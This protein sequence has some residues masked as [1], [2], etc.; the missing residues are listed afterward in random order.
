[1]A[2][3][4]HGKTCTIVLFEQPGGEI[5]TLFL[6]EGV[7]DTS[8][9]VV[10]LLPQEGSYAVRIPAHLVEDIEPVTDE[11]RECIEGLASEYCLRAFY[12]GRVKRGRIDLDA[13]LAKAYG[14]SASE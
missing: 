9:D 14:P 8:G 13:I 2:F 1:M 7:L 11:H 6:V 3:T 12:D 10:F 4:P 5:R